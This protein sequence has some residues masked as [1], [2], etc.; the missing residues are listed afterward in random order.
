MPG[1]VVSI[2]GGENCPFYR[3]TEA[4]Q[5]L[6]KRLIGEAIEEAREEHGLDVSSL[7]IEPK[8]HTS[9]LEPHCCY[10][11]VKVYDRYA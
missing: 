7:R 2:R 11:E 4:R 1:P 8:Y 6:I 10:G 5:N 9:R 3:S